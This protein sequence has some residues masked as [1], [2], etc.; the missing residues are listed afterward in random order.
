MQRRIAVAALFVAF[1][2]MALAHGNEEHVMGT[3]TAVGDNIITVKTTAGKL[4]EVAIT[5]KTA[6][7][8]AGQMVG[9]KEIKVGDRVVIHAR[10]TGDRLEATTVQLGRSNRRA[11]AN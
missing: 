3:V 8:R 1:A 2:V 9:V 4:T 11:G 10:K 6:F 7:S 5:E